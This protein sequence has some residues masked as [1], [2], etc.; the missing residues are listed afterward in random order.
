[1]SLCFRSWW[2][3][4]A[5]LFLCFDPLFGSLRW[6]HSLL[7]W[8]IPAVDVVGCLWSGP[9]LATSSSRDSSCLLRRSFSMFF[10]SPQLSFAPLGLKSLSFFFFWSKSRSWG[11]M[12]SHFFGSIRY[13]G[14]GVFALGIATGLVNATERSEAKVWKRQK[15]LIHI[16]PGYNIIYIFFVFLFDHGY[17]KVFWTLHS[18]FVFDV[19]VWR[20]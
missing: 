3:R 8:W 19:D 4:C 1:M 18:N 17:A 12:F 11:G 7:Y 20:L 2:A 5:F 10:C 13:R 16:D 6:W 15:S 9:P 14:M